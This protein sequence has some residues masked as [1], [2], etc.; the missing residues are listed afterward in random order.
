MRVQMEPGWEEHVERAAHTFLKDEIAPDILR[1]MQANCPVDTGALKASLSSEVQGLHARIGS[2]KD[3]AIYV[4]EGTAPHIIRA[5]DGG[6][7]F[8]P[9]AGHPVTEVHHPGTEAT[10]FMKR[11]LYEAE[12][13]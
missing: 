13:G 5:H 12:R 2:D 8:W 1:N 4:E 6:A 7:L 3:Y 10:H 11:S 9:G